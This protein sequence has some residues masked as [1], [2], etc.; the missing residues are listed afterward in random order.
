MN[1]LWSSGLETLPINP[2]LYVR[3]TIR[4]GGFSVIY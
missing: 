1:I 2:L 4:H 3:K